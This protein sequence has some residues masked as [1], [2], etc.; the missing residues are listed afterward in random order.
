VGKISAFGSGLKKLNE[1]SK[2]LQLRSNA[3]EPV[4]PKLNLH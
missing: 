3:I 2:G 4:E 1:G